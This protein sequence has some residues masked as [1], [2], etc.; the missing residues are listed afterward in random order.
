MSI[1][2]VR[3]DQNYHQKGIRSSA[4]MFQEY[5]FAIDC[6]D[7]LP[8]KT[9]M[10]HAS[11]LAILENLAK[12]PSAY[13]KLVDGVS[14]KEI[15]YK[16]GTVHL[17]DFT[18]PGVEFDDIAKY[19]G[20]L[21]DHFKEFSPILVDEITLGFLRRVSAHAPNQIGNEDHFSVL[22]SNVFGEIFKIPREAR[23]LKKSVQEIFDQKV[24]DKPN[25]KI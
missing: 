20:I 11:V 2:L 24:P 6:K 25:R 13:G 23:L 12:E 22:A 10:K 5:A 16:A 9:R 7:E 4:P 21:K 8:I 15:K 17:I 14:H 1:I 18:S 3:T 19:Q